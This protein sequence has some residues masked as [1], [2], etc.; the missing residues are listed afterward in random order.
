MSVRETHYVIWGAKIPKIDYDEH[1]DLI[2]QYASTVY[3]GGKKNQYNDV[4]LVS[5]GMDDDWYIVGH[6]FEMASGYD[7]EGLSFHSLP[8]I[9][10][11]ADKW[12]IASRDLC[13]MFG[14]KLPEPHEFGWIVFTQYR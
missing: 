11:D 3:N 6:V 4:C 2:D 5:G 14:V 7:G 8:S 12:M 13:G 9:P 1:E 10:A